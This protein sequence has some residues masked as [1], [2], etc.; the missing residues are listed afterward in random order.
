[1]VLVDLLVQSRF[2]L[3]QFSPSDL[4][5]LYLQTNPA[6]PSDLLDPSDP[7]DLSDQLDRCQDLLHQ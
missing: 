6:S 7:S 5:D 3:D 1:M 2:P 4:S